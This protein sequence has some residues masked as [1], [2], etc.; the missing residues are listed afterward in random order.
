MTGYF[1][2]K[3]TI[4]EVRKQKP[5]M[6]YYG[7]ITCW[8]THDVR[9]LCRIPEDRQGAGLPCDPRGGVLLQTDD[10]DGFFKAAE[11][12]PS[13]YGKHGIKAFEAAH[14]LNCT[15]SE[16][17]RRSTC[18]REWDDYNRILDESAAGKG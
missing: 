14:H 11:D 13:H 6:I 17:D 1:T 12:N 16:S 10:I 4:D 2:G 5:A 3:I 18:F 9:H 7:A 8:W 15:V